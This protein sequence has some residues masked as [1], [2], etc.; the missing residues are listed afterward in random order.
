MKR[1]LV[2]FV[3][4]CFFAIIII[5]LKP[6]KQKWEYAA[7]QNSPNRPETSVSLEIVYFYLHKN[8]ILNVSTA[9]FKILEMFYWFI[10]LYTLFFIQNLHNYLT[11]Y[12]YLFYLDLKI[13]DSKT[14][15]N[16]V[17]FHFFISFVIKQPT[18]QKV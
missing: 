9:L 16:Y 7:T 4:F 5:Y 3:L 12:Y 8:Q 13:I 11:K 1:V 17:L 6:F 2:F 18:N 15:V 10:K 14:K